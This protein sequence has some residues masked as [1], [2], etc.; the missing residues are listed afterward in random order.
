MAVEFITGK[1]GGGKTLYAVNLIVRELRISKRPIITN[2]PGKIDLV[3]EY[4]Q[5]T[6]PEIDCDTCGR[7]RLL[8]EEE[9]REFYLVRGRYEKLTVRSV[10]DGR[11]VLDKSQ[12]V[13][14]CLYVLDEIHTVFGSRS[15]QKNGSSALWYMSQQRHFGDDVVMITQN[16]QQ[17]DKQLRDLG[18]QYHYVENLSKVKFMGLRGPAGR[19]L[20]ST[21][22]TPIST[23]PNGMNLCVETQVT[24]MDMKIASLYDTSAGV[25]FVGGGGAD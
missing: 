23:S 9:L 25:G 20:R 8:E 12:P 13:T 7:L 18:E 17:I 19:F 4:M 24:K 10:V 16:L 21:F 6:Y 3:N 5:Q 22:L 2:V 15:W 1:M 14:P 11:P